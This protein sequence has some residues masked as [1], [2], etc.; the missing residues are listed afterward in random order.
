MN[1][2]MLLFRRDI[3]GALVALAFVSCSD[4]QQPAV[5]PTDPTTPAMDVIPSTEASLLTGER[6][7][8]I[9]PRHV[10]LDLGGQ[11]LL[12]AATYHDG[13][14]VVADAG[15]SWSSLDPEIAS[16]DAL[17]VVTAQSVGVTSIIAEQIC[18]ERAD[19]A[20]IVVRQAPVSIV[21]SAPTL[22]F[23]PNETA[24]LNA[25]VYDL[26]GAPISNAVLT[27]SSSDAEVATV[28]QGVVTA[29]TAGRAAIYVSTGA[30][31]DS[32]VV[33]V[34][35]AAQP[36]QPD[37]QQPGEPQ[38]DE[39]KPD[40]PKRDEPKRDEPKP[41]EQP[42]EGSP[43]G[44]PDGQPQPAPSSPVLTR[45]AITPASATVSVGAASQL[46][47]VALDQ[48]GR[49]MSGQT[50]AWSTSDPVVALVSATGLVTGVM[51]GIA[52]V[53]ASAGGRI[54]TAQI[55]I[56][57][58]QLPAPTL[59]GGSFS[60]PDIAVT[61][62]STGSSSPFT[63][64][65]GSVTGNADINIMSDPTGLM[66]GQI[67]RIHFVRSSTGTSPDVNRALQF[68]R[69]VYHGQTVFFRGRIMIPTP[70]ANMTH[71][72]RKLFYVQTGSPSS[73]FCVIKADGTSLKAE[74]TN[75]RLFRIG[76][77][78]F[79]KPFWIEAQITVNSAPGVADGI[80]R[81][82]QDGVLVVDHNDV[83]WID[84]Q[85]AGQNF[86]RFMFGQQAQ[87]DAATTFDEYRYWDNIAISTRR[88]GP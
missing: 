87:M 28:N 13:N 38:R 58:G 84:N 23:T 34:T 6:A 51:P 47:A 24:A 79:G 19:T 5:D 1:Q 77:I 59:P 70:A 48:N 46:R 21:V 18:C 27:W 50:F 36:E 82:W 66:G 63:V 30:L 10:D 2:G 56:V 12:E 69:S 14:R 73:S 33:T 3:L 60:A 62:F 80:F 35:T 7:V 8:S 83:E 43:E 52:I 71:A 37:E 44:S 72:M 20:V 4:N 64:A 22:S 32:T 55:I 39:P 68:R 9:T 31:T 29:L 40:E 67:A 11:T 86:N 17:G 45:I 76:S 49:S 15:F 65:S 26:A 61:D 25:T 81:V 16:V 57:S 42:G 75:S 41:D 85:A 78:P 53:S 74:V 54:A 88:I